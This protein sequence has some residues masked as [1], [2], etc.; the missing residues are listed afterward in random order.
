VVKGIEPVSGY[1]PHVSKSAL[2][3]FLREEEECRQAEQDEVDRLRELNE[4]RKREWQER[5]KAEEDAKRT[6]RRRNSRRVA[7]WSWSRL[8][9]KSATSGSSIIRI[10][11]MGRLLEARD[12]AQVCKIVIINQG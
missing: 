11:R 4:Q 10:K 5:L 8:R 2:E 7:S 6:R 1:G 12:R 9:C 3:Q